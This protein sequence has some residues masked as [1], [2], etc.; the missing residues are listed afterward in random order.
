MKNRLKRRWLKRK[1]A[2]SS[3]TELQQK[4]RIVTKDIRIDISKFKDKKIISAKGVEMEHR[5]RL[6]SQGKTIDVGDF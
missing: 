4:K 2:L 5:K 3:L 6:R 1:H